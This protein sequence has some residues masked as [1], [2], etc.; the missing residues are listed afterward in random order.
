MQYSRLYEFIP[1]PFRIARGV[2]IPVGGYGFDN[3]RVTYNAG[4]QHRVS[5]SDVVQRR[6]LLRGR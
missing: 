1:E 6:H 2:I 4:S 5:G 3:V